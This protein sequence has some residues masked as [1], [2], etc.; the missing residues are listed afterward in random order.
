MRSLL[1]SLTVNA[2]KQTRSLNPEHPS[3]RRR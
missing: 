3:N 1:M 2:S